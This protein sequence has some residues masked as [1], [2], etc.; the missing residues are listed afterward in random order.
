VA[1]HI[2]PN[3]KADFSRCNHNPN[4][5]STEANGSNKLKKI[6]LNPARSLRITKNFINTEKFTMV[7]AIKAPKLTRLTTVAKSTTI[8]S[9]EIMPTKKIEYKGVP[10]RAF[11]EP[12]TFWLNTP[13][14]PMIYSN[15]DA[16]AC[17]A[18]PDA[19]A[20]MI[21][22]VNSADWK[23]TPPTY[24]AISGKASRSRLDDLALSYR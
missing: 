5:H 1:S 3:S 20:F 23:N 22:T 8:A 16:L 11:T 21:C 18:K 12:N 24:S 9:N 14:R 7:K 2:P 19:K 10:N 15:R 17:E 4:K 6:F 13:S